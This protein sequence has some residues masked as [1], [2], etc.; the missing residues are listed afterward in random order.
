MNEPA[1]RTANGQTIVGKV[2]R[3]EPCCLAIS[4]ELRWG[5]AEHPQRATRR[6]RA[7]S[8]DGRQELIVGDLEINTDDPL[9]VV[10]EK[11]AMAV[12]SRGYEPQQFILE[13][14][15]EAAP[16]RGRIVG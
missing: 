3:M 14:P 5:A 11:A 15:L 13:K 12:R 4:S 10:R 8:L 16:H 2:A 6:W 7:L 1:P 9:G